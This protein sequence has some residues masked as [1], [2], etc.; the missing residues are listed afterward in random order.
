MILG[1]S[2]IIWGKIHLYLDFGIL[3]DLFLFYETL[4]LVVCSCSMIS[5]WT[6]S[7]KDLKLTLF[8]SFFLWYVKLLGKIMTYVCGIW[9]ERGSLSLI[10]YLR[11]FS[12]YFFLYCS[13]VSS[14]WTPFFCNLIFLVFLWT[15]R[16]RLAIWEIF[17]I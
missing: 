17:L 5:W 8:S 3:K 16:F 15:I 13:S 6:H 12:S 14:S 4:A 7:V 9:Q 10:N 11:I 1:W 2:L